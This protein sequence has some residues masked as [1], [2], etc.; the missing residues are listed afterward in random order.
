MEPSKLQ[1][2]ETLAER[3][4]DD[5]RPD[6]ME[7]IRDGVRHEAAA[8]V[9]M[10]EDPLSFGSAQEMVLLFDVTKTVLATLSLEFL[11]VV[12]S[13]V[14]KRVTQRWTSPSVPVHK[15]DL[16]HLLVSY[17]KTL[18]RHGFDKDEAS[19][20]AACLGRQLLENPQMLKALMTP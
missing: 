1:A 18:R 17:E 14:A 8:D 11:K 13:D 7:F 12:S 19:R 16:R 3:I 10:G 5:V 4:T 2:I 20:A 9:R 15:E 6:E